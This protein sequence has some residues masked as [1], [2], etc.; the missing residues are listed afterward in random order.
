MKVYFFEKFRLVTKFINKTRFMQPKQQDHLVI[1]VPAGTVK[2]KAI[3]EGEKVVQS[4]FVNVPS[5]LYLKDNTIELGNF[6]SIKFDVSFGGAFYAIVDAGQLQLSLD[7]NNFEACIKLGR[8]IKKAVMKSYDILHP[9]SK[10]LSFL[11]GTI[12]TGNAEQK[13]HHSRNVCI[14]ADGEVDRCPTGSGVSGRMAI[15]YLRNE[16]KIRVVVTLNIT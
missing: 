10:D 11:Y 16:I 7:Q 2:A 13:N 8:E 9:V 6:G 15:H 4:S 3:I 1:N 12:F 14:F 5:F